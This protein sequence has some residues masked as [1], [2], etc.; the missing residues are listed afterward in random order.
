[1]KRSDLLRERIRLAHLAAY[2][3][4]R[5]TTAGKKPAKKGNNK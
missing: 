5:E 4:K 1:V 2:D 3:Q